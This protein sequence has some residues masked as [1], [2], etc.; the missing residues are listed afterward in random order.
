MSL[1]PPSSSSTWFPPPSDLRRL[2]NEEVR[3]LFRSPDSLLRLDVHRADFAAKRSEVR[4]L[5]SAAIGAQVED[6][7]Q[8]AALLQ[9]TKSLIV[10]VRDNFRRIDDYCL[11]VQRLIVDVSVIRRVNVS[12]RN[13]DATIRLLDKFRSLP[14]QCDDLLDELYDK[15]RHIK[16]VYR[17]LRKLMLLRDT[18][19]DPSI[20]AG[21]SDDFT[22]E[23]RETFLHLSDAADEVELRIWENVGDSFFLAKSDPTV[24][25][26]T[27]EVVEM[28][29]RAKR[30]AFGGQA[31]QQGAASGAVEGKKKST[32]KAPSLAPIG[33]AQNGVAEL[34]GHRM[35]ERCLLTLE[36]AIAD[37]F[38]DLHKDEAQAK[39]EKREKEKKKK[40]AEEKK[41]KAEALRAKRREDRGGDDDDEEDGDGD[42]AEA[43]GA[44]DDDDGGGGGAV[45]EEDEAEAESVS[46]AVSDYACEVLEQ[47]Q[48]LVEQLDE[49][50]AVLGP[51]FPPS[52]SIIDFY[53]LRYRHWIKVTINFHTN[54][55]S[56]LSKK[57]LLKTVSWMTWYMDRLRAKQYLTRQDEDEW[58]ALQHEM[59]VTFCQATEQTITALVDNIL[60]A[61]E[62]AEAEANESGHF[63]TTG[64]ADLFYTINQQMDIVLNAYAL[65]SHALGHVCLMLA[66]IFTYYQNAQLRFLSDIE[67]EDSALLFGD[68]RVQRDEKYFTAVI[69]NCELCRDNMDE[70]KDKSLQRIRQ[71]AQL[72][73]VGGGARLSPPPSS[74]ASASTSSSSPTF[75]LERL[76]RDIEDAFDDC[77]EGFISVASEA[78]DILVLQIMTVMQG[79]LEALFSAQW[80]EDPTVSQD[81]TSTLKDFFDDLGQWISRDAY[82]SRVVRLCLHSLCQ[83]YARRLIETRPQLSVEF[84]ER[85]K[86]DQVLLDRFFISGYGQLIG[87]QLV[88]SELSFIQL[89][90]ETLQADV[91]SL[92]LHFDK[93]TA[94][95]PGDQGMKVIDTLLTLRPDLNRAGRK[96][97]VEHYTQHVLAHAQQQRAQRERKGGAAGEGGDAVVTEAPSSSSS[98]ARPSSSSFIAPNSGLWSLFQSRAKPVSKGKP[99]Q[100]EGK[101]RKQRRQDGESINLEDFLK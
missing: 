20:S 6:V 52:Y 48:D 99:S 9:T 33:G 64:P 70:L 11:D 81:L 62:Q 78:V 98:G 19:F 30:K 41:K 26:R 2:A 47:M 76:S 84:F 40:R 96:A 75:S 59:I 24:L 35:K 49:M 72:S 83:E 10:Q 57:A 89:I 68:S 71:D 95:W 74:S 58:N 39:K 63:H 16:A 13:V 94:T 28:E 92:Q 91:D 4:Q 97:V 77:G 8:G 79:P 50:V 54:D 60:R 27:L 55:V 37:S 25:I 36:K 12:R 45:D 21:F 66:D 43:D 87:E 44:D 38:A 14:D 17:G 100:R 93:M 53:E 88:T 3:S 67:L 15:D 69:N 22:R 29:D 34:G 86:G 82:F 42:G 65:K 5:L 46:D 31:A 90:Q 73:G 1:S 23:L 18:A 7:K 51:C 85:L 61:E 56:K 80:L 101:Q 32:K